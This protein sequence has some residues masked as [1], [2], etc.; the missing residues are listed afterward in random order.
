MF[1]VTRDSF[2][3]L[4]T[5]VYFFDFTNII[6][7]KLYFHWY[8]WHHIGDFTAAYCFK[9]GA[10][11]VIITFEYEFSITIFASVNQKIYNAALYNKCT[12]DRIFFCFQ[13]FFKFK[14]T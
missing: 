5:E 13:S 14:H 10:V 12:N 3:A 7:R 9:S 8:T 1:Y 2:Y 6:Y 4:F 11:F